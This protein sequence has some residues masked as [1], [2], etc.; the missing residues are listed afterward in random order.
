LNYLSFYGVGKRENCDGNIREGGAV[1]E[2]DGRTIDKSTMVVGDSTI[3]IVGKGGKS[4]YG[5]IRAL[6]G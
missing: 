1:F 3:S 5:P 4:H 6:A 2:G